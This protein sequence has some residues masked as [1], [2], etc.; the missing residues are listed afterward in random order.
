MNTL[1]AHVQ[2]NSSQVSDKD[3]VPSHYKL[4]TM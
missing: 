4:L 3:V 2:M 1:Q